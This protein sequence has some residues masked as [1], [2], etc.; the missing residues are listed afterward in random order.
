M[1]GRQEDGVVTNLR[2]T[3]LIDI[4]FILLLFFIVTS[5]IMKQAGGRLGE[6]AY[7]KVQN[8]F[9]ESQQVNAFLTVF[10]FQNGQGQLKYRLIHKGQAKSP[11]G[12]FAS[13]A[14]EAAKKEP[15]TNFFIKTTPILLKSGPLA[16]EMDRLTSTSIRDVLR[17]YKTIL[18][19][20]DLN[21]AIVAQPDIP[22]FDVIELYSFMKAPVEDNGLGASSVVL[23]E[24]NG[25][26][27]ELI[28]RI[29]GIEIQ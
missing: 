24:F 11:V 8:V 14:R 5:V 20:N 25:S 2:M 29:D 23:L 3:S 6:R 16:Q 22:F 7:L 28:G 10:I 27:D 9:A 15:D 1:L 21:F 12:Y 18:A 17:D 4:I 13:L 26:L 19:E